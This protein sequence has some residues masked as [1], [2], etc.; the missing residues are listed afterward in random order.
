A[1]PA[2][3]HRGRRGTLPGF[4]TRSLGRLCRPEPIAGGAEPSQGSELDRWDGFAG[5]S[6]SREA[7]NPPRVPNS[8]VGTALP[9]R[10]H[11]G[12]RGTLPGFR[13]RSLG[14]LCRPE[15]IAGGAEPSQGSELDRWDGFAG[16]SPSREAR[17][18]PRVPNSI[19]GTALPARAHRGR[20]GTLPGFRTRSLGRLCRSEPIAGGAEPSQGSELNQS[21]RRT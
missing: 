4:R 14:R 20:C 19:V 11:R 15:P 16:P 10:A 3:A 7:R 6:P 2:R 5:P 8:I 1:L 21:A 13:T 9:A 12:R 18:P 17:N